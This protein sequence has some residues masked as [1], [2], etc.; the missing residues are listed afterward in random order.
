M[1]P[2]DPSLLPQLLLLSADTP[3][4]LEQETA[5]LR[6]RLL[7]SDSSLSDS[8]LRCSGSQGCRPQED[9]GLR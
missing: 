4:A 3:D 2:A 7:Q 8:L 9:A 6:Q 1:T 5:D